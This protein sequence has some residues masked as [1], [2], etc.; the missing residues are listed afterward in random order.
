MPKM[1][2]WEQWFSRRFT[3]LV[4]GRDYYC[5]QSS[6]AQ[7]VRNNASTR[8][9]RVSVTDLG[10]GIIIEVRGRVRSEVP[11]TDQAP[12]AGQCQDALA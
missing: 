9:L 6:M 4:S 5:S 8:R 2:C 12:V 11:H 10:Y 7:S 1:Y 3:L